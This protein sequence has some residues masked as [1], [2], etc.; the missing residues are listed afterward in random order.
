MKDVRAVGHYEIGPLFEVERI[1]AISWT[2]KDRSIR[3]ID[4]NIGRSADR[5]TALIESTSNVI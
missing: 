3:H 1:W 2:M 5:R 4:R